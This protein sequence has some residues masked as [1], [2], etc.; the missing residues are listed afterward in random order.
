[1]SRLLFTPFLFRFLKTSEEVGI[2]AELKGLGGTMQ[3][4]TKLVRKRSATRQV[5]VACAVALAGAS[6]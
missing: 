3:P 4:S 1:M 5:A 6:F 2:A